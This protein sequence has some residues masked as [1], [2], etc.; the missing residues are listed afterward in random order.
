MNK[1]IFQT[2]HVFCNKIYIFL[3]YICIHNL[4]VLVLFYVRTYLPTYLI[5]YNTLYNSLI[6]DPYLYNTLIPDLKHFFGKILNSLGVNYS[7]WYLTPSHFL[8]QLWASLYKLS[9]AQKE[10]ISLGGL[11]TIFGDF[12]WNV[13]QIDFLSWF[14][15][16]T[17]KVNKKS[18]YKDAQP[19]S[20]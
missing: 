11:R 13:Y 17:L 1:N 18:W 12:T 9:F 10:K 4:L 20:H 2:Y 14:V 16:S 8:I 15:A 3:K 19:I 5:L 7:K 6:P